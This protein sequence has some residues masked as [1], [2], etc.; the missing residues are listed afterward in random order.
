M[1]FGRTQLMQLKL[2]FFG[3]A[4]DLV[5]KRILDV[6]CREGETTKDVYSRV[7]EDNPQLASQKLHLSINQQYAKGDEIVREGDEIAIFAP[8]S[9]G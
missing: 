1:D 5:G 8:V 7:L 2:L 4:A 6:E 9:G 3:S